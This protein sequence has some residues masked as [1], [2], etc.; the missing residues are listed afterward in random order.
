MN[1]VGL[2]RV[3]NEA[4][5]IERCI[6]SILPACSRVIVM[7]DHSTDGTPEICSAIPAVE[8]H[9]SPF[10]GLDEARDKNWLLDQARDADWIL[11]I[12]GDEMLEAGGAAKLSKAAEAAAPRVKALAFRVLYLWD[13]EEQYRVDGVYGRLARASM[14]RPGSHR[15]IPTGVGGNFHCGNV[16]LAL[17]LDSLNPG[18]ALLHFGYLHK[19]DR[20]RKYHWYREQD[21]NNKFEDGYRHMVIGDLFPAHSEF[22]HAGPLQL[23]ALCTRP[24]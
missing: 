18:L 19:G 10:T 7:D 21:P 11:M 5:W 8:V 9:D 20:I 15:F 16:P 24:I 23:E 6:R 13:T 12:D 17:Q 14:F 1:I 4:R 22:R 3:K 2:M